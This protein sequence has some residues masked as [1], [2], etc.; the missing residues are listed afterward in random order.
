MITVGD[1][2]KYV[3]DEIE[4]EN[5]ELALEHVA[6]AIDLTSQ[7]YYKSSKSSKLNYKNF[8][9]EYSWL[10]ELMA[11]FGINLDESKFGNYPIDG[12][13]EPSF[14]DLIYHVIRCNLVHAEGVPENFEFSDVDMIT[15]NKD[16]LVF[17]KRLIWGL[18]APVV[19]CPVNETE[20]TEV[21]YY[22]SIFQNRFHINDFWGKEEVARH[23]YDKRQ[24]IRV[25]IIALSDRIIREQSELRGTVLGTGN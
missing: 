9:K 23:V 20:L 11:F 15:V 3:I 25:S 7:K 10:I 21:G 18:L 19:F 5:F 16:H 24:P 6:I 1:R 17:P 2:V 22:I 12:N 14:Q 13:P 4:K 8:L